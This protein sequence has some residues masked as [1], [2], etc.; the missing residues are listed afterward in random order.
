MCTPRSQMI[1]ES[2]KSQ[3]GRWHSANS[4][5]KR[6]PLFTD[7]RSCS[8][9][10]TLVQSDIF[11]FWRISRDFMAHDTNGW[12]T[13]AGTW[14]FH[15]V[16]YF[17][18]IPTFSGTYAASHLPWNLEVRAGN[19]EFKKL[20]NGIL[21]YFA[22]TNRIATCPQIEFGNFCVYN[23]FNETQIRQNC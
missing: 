17:H 11:E 10:H 20:Q 15:G 13:V 6:L 9:W 16:H 22:H 5:I 2:T 14:I 21:L 4:A 3:F 12:Y 8:L 7:S 23:W 18:V 19:D 1:K